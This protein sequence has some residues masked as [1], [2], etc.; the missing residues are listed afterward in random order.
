[1]PQG[2]SEH[3][4]LVKT[5]MER[6]NT[7]KKGLAK[8]YPALKEISS[9]ATALKSAAD[10]ADKAFKDQEAYCAKLIEKYAT[11]ANEI[12]E[13]EA[14]LEDAKGDKKAEA[15]LLKKHKKADAEATALREA[16]AKAM[17]VFQTLS[18]VVSEARGKVDGATDK[19]ESARAGG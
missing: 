7:M 17:E 5:A 15:E 8:T 1:M 16:Y 18:D 9:S 12:A 10:A 6:F 3:P 13:I 14:D 4:G 2:K 11:K 19:F